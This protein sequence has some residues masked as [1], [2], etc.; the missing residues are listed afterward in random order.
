[1]TISWACKR[2]E[3]C[4]QIMIT[5]NVTLQINKLRKY[6]V[7]TRQETKFTH[8]Y[9]CWWQRIAQLH[10]FLVGRL[11]LCL[12]DWIS[13]GL[14]IG[15]DFCYCWTFYFSGQLLVVWDFTIYMCSFYIVDSL[16]WIKKNLWIAPPPPSFPS[17]PF[18]S[19]LQLRFFFFS[20]FFFPF[21]LP[22]LS[23]SFFK[24]SCRASK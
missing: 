3:Y 24:S 22:F 4:K 14:I 9:G 12:C 15:L 11:G 7:D 19:L 6:G 21:F 20:S 10:H 17:L 13:F 1:M 18:S 8:M 5:G 23:F 16:W 2:K